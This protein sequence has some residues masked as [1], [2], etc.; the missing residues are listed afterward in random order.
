VFAYTLV[1]TSKQQQHGEEEEE[2][3][4]TT[5]MDDFAIVQLLLLALCCFIGIRKLQIQYVC[6]D[7]QVLS[8][9]QCE[10]VMLAFVMS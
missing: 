9:R 1:Q 8:G 7:R 6:L 3:A 2:E 5:T 10:M 4:A